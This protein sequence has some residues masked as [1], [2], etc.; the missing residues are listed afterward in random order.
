MAV[1]ECHW[2]ARASR[3]LSCRP[4]PLLG[5]LLRPAAPATLGVCWS[6]VSGLTQAS[7]SQS[8]VSHQGPGQ[9]ECTVKV[10]SWVQSQLSVRSASVSP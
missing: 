6:A 5:W 1:T 2:D 3:T 4:H 10:Q 9:P 7:G 8:A